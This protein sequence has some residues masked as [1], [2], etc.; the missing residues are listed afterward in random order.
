MKLKLLLLLIALAALT[1]TRAQTKSTPVIPPFALVELFT[2]EGDM[3]SP[4]ADEL[5]RKIKSDALKNNKPVYTVAYHVDYWNKY[6]WKDPYSKLQFTYL[7]RNYMSALNQ[8]EMFTPQMIVNGKYP[9]TGS[10]E[11]KIKSA[12]DKSLKTNAY[13]SISIKKDS[14]VNDTLYVSYQSSVASNDY[15]IKVLLLE[16]GL[17]STVTAGD[18]K[19]KTLLHENVCRVYQSKSLNAK[20]GQLKIPVNGIRFNLNMSLLAFVQKKGTLNVLGICTGKL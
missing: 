16:S 12:I 19:G 7:Q 10:D 8:K 9:F 20:T 13:C 18:N 5:L 3:A 1:H 14:V 15:S 4:P 6:G 17:K 11:T 2:S